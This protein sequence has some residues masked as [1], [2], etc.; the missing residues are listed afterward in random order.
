MGD[1]SNIIIEDGDKDKRVYLYGHWMGLDYIE[2]LAKALSRAKDRW[3]DAAYIARVIF[4]DMVRND[5]D[6]TTGY[7]IA[8]SKP[9]NEYPYLVL[10]CRKQTVT[11]ETEDGDVLLSKSIEAFIER[12]SLFSNRVRER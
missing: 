11:L 9:D 1:R 3:D 6:G 4:C 10:D 12:P 7:G 8:T 5:L 2:I